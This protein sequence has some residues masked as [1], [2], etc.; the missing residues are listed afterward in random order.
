MDSFI[1]F[2]IEE[3]KNTIVERGNN[4]SGKKGNIQMYQIDA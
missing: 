4:V 3:K 1:V 2:E